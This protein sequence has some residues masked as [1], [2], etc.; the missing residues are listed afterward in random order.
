MVT[1]FTGQY[2]RVGPVS[3]VRRPRSQAHLRRPPPS[4]SDY[5]SYPGER[6]FSQIPHMGL[7]TS[8]GSAVAPRFLKFPEPPLRAEPLG[9][10]GLLH[11]PDRPRLS[12]GSVQSTN[13]LRMTALARRFAAGADPPICALSH[14]RRARRAR[15]RARSPKIGRQAAAR[16]YSERCCGMPASRARTSV[17]RYRRWPPSVRMD[18]NFPAFAQRVTVLGST[19]NIVATSAGVSNGSASGVRAD[20]MTASPPGPCLAILRLMGSWLHSEPALD[21]L[22]GLLLPYCHHQR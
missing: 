16:R 12:P 20:I 13:T 9:F 21:V 11:R 2:R 22:Y 1:R 17:S 3:S 10:L 14:T 7:R 5:F 15:T 18:V 8:R 6:T 4:L 19:R